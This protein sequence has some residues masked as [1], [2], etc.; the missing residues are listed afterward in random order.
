M[1]TLSGI[2]AEPGPGQHMTLEDIL[3]LYGKATPEAR[4]VAFDVLTQDMDV[5]QGQLE[6]GEVVPNRWRRIESWLTSDANQFSAYREQIKGVSTHLEGFL[7]PPVSSAETKPYTPAPRLCGNPAKQQGDMGG[8]TP[9]SVINSESSHT[10][11]ESTGRSAMSM[12]FTIPPGTPSVFSM[13][14]ESPFPPGRM[15]PTRVITHLEEVFAPVD[16][17]TAFCCHTGHGPTAPCSEYRLRSTAH[18]TAAVP[19]R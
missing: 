8:G 2:T 14:P 18:F 19:P 11:V 5:L 7:S 3:Y 16:T 9:A 4:D 12:P 6:K 17:D 10:A 1:K 15:P 13:A